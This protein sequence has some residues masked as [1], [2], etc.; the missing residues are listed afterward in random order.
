MAVDWHIAGKIK[1]EHR[2]SV[3]TQVQ[4]RCRDA[5]FSPEIPFYNWPLLSPTA[6]WS[7]YFL[8]M[9][10]DA[11][12]VLLLVITDLAFGLYLLHRYSPPALLPRQPL[13]RSF[14]RRL[15]HLF[16]RVRRNWPQARRELFTG[17]SYWVLVTT[18]V[19]E[20]VLSFVYPILLTYLN[21]PVTH[22][23]YVRLPIDFLIWD[24]VLLLLVIADDD[25]DSSGDSPP[26]P[27]SWP[28][29]ARPYPY[30]TRRPTPPVPPA[31]RRR[32]SRA[33]SGN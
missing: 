13:A 30:R 8:L 12:N 18:L 32:G 16:G 24:A 4:L 22:L 10:S 25:D 1:A 28:L 6:Q 26:A 20:V 3:R 19:G 31:L 14:V 7:I 21:F 17:R 23:D 11:L 33:P 5:Y 9:L 29:L 15:H 27:P 2:Y